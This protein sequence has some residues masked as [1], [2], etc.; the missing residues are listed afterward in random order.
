[1]ASATGYFID[2]YINGAWKQIG[3]VT[4]TSCTVNSLHAGATYYFAIGATNSSGTTFAN[5]KGVTTL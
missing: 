1:M 2:E 4:G 3:T 5:Y